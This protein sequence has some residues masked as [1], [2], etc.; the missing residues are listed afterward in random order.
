MGKFA[1]SGLERDSF[2]LHDPL[3]VAVALDPSLVKIEEAA[4]AVDC[5][6]EELGRTR[7]VGPGQ[8]RVAIDVD[9][10]RALDEFRRTVGLPERAS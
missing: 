9:A 2:N 1:F 6:G 4:V 7:V 3:S 8:V 10:E 5:E